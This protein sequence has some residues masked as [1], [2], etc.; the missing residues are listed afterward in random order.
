MTPA[1][2]RGWAKDQ[3]YRLAGDTGNRTGWDSL[4]RLPSILEKP[5]P[6]WTEEDLAFAWKVR[7]F[8]T[9]HIKS[10][11]DR[12]FGREVGRSGYSKRHIALRNWGH[13]PGRKSSELYQ[14][15]LEWLRE[16]PGAQDRRGK[17]ANRQANPRRRVRSR[18]RANPSKR[19][20]LSDS[21]FLERLKQVEGERWFR[22][23]KE[24]TS[25][26]SLG[27][28]L[29]TWDTEIE[30][31]L[32]SAELSLEDDMAEFVLYGNQG[33]ARYVVSLLGYV[34]L[35]YG[36]ILD[37]DHIRRARELNIPGSWAEATGK[38]AKAKRADNPLVTTGTAPQRRDNPMRLPE[39][40][41]EDAAVFI[42][43]GAP[44]FGPRTI[45]LS[46]WNLAAGVQ[47]Q[48]ME[49]LRRGQKRPYGWLVLAEVD[50]TQ[51]LWE[52]ELANAQPGWGPMLY[53]LA[54]EYLWETRE[55]ALMPDRNGVSN[56]ALGVWMTYW[57]RR[58]DVER[59][60]VP[61][62]LYFTQIVQGDN[63]P[64]EWPALH[65][66]YFKRATPLMDQ[67]SD[68]EQLFVEVDED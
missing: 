63:D 39:D 51:G 43:D 31:Y 47:Q 23:S 56:D 64:L 45:R 41:P 1:E 37:K 3:R 27:G 25:P 11:K 4:R 30:P 65:H 18:R 29:K 34:W 35:D 42:H 44:V 61:E 8:N 14:D 58:R 55:G 46:Y 53:D 12:L 13:D 50:P 33:Y 54:M 21:D 26:D 7:N 48:P 66:A 2:L 49:S 38:P 10:D 6:Q 20:H 68:T 67:L 57:E 5:V 9:R 15:D 52:V 19:M 22:L 60:L 59:E 32:G 36:S 40:L 17:W 16:H 24:S 62:G 28:I